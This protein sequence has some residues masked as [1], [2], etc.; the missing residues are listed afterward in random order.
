[1][2][3]TVI[4]IDD[5]QD[6][7]D[8]VKETIQTIDDTIHCICFVHPDEALRMITNAPSVIPDYIFSD[9][10]MPKMGE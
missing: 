9:V 2:P 4:L 10:N 3:K 7:L 1:M 5:D 8:I 6:D